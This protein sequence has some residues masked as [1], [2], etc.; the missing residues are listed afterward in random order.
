VF[1]VHPTETCDEDAP[2]L[3]TD[4]QTT[5]ATVL[6]NEV[7]PLVQEALKEYAFFTRSLTT[8]VLRT[9]RIWRIGIGEHASV[10]DNFSLS[11]VYWI[12]LGKYARISSASFPSYEAICRSV[13]RVSGQASGEML[14]MKMREHRHF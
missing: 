12:Q 1:K 2:H 14:S 6:D 3:I 5:V 9:V 11:T 4:V 10:R 8:Y 7:N 13:F